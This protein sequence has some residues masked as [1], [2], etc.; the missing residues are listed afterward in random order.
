MESTEELGFI[1]QNPFCSHIYAAVS[2]GLPLDGAH[3]VDWLPWM[4]STEEL[5]Y[6]RRNPLCSHLYAA[7]SIGLLPK[8]ESVKKMDQPG[9]NK[10]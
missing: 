9:W 2:V 8:I 4:E 1:G 10:D 6:L 3:R 5:G 7:V